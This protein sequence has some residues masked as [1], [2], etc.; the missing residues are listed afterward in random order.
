MIRACMHTCIGTYMYD[1]NDDNHSMIG[2]ITPRIVNSCSLRKIIDKNDEWRKRPQPLKP[3]YRRS[4]RLKGAEQGP[5]LDAE[6]Q[7]WLLHL[8]AEEAILN[9]CHYNA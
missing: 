3:R 5:G 8:Q 2:T 1:D 7:R 9:N 4:K 6:T